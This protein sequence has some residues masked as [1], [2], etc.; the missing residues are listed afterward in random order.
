[1]K[2]ADTQTVENYFSN[3]IAETEEAMEAQKEPL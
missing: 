3:A 1:L 2:T